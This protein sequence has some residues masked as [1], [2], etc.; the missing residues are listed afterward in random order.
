[1]SQH[2]CT[3]ECVNTQAENDEIAY[4]MRDEYRKHLKG[5]P[6]DWT[7]EYEARWR[8]DPKDWAWLNKGE[9]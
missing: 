3:S 2:E 1:M 5:L 4:L 7:E 8:K 6:S 9:E